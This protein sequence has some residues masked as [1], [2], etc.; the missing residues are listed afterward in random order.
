MFVLHRLQM[1]AHQN[2]QEKACGRDTKLKWQEQ[3]KEE[4]EEGEE[5]DK[6]E[7]KQDKEE[8]EAGK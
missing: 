5:Q 6:E 8:G 1:A 7:D 4:G 2:G 3:D